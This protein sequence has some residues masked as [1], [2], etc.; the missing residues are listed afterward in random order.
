[1]RRG[2]D[3]RLLAL[4]ASDRLGGQQ[5]VRPFVRSGVP[6]GP[7]SWSR[8][9]PI[10]VGT[11]TDGRTLSSRRAVSSS[12]M[13]RSVEE[14]GGGL[15]A[16]RGP[17][18]LAKRARALLLLFPVVGARALRARAA[19]LSF[20]PLLGRSR[21]GRRRRRRRSRER[22]ARAN[23]RTSLSPRRC[24][25]LTHT[26]THTSPTD[27]KSTRRRHCTLLVSPRPELQTENRSEA[28]EIT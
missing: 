21:T 11:R 3:Q 25:A 2:P 15:S 20:P 18:S 12:R 28:D 9:T 16:R 27:S 6:K 7:S 22:A 4:D 26:Y 19:P 23:A 24:R 10:P 14:R 1:V 13:Q 8:R 17:H 5:F